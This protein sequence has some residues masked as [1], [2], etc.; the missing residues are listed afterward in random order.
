MNGENMV[1]AAAVAARTKL[2]VLNTGAWRATRL[3]RG[4]TRAQ[5]RLHGTG[6]KAKVTVRITDHPALH[7][8]NK[9][10]AAAYAAH[11]RITLP[12]VQDG[13]RLVP[14]GRELE[15]SSVM[16]KFADEHN[17]LVAEFLADYDAE[18]EAAPAKLN[19]LYDPSMWP[20]RAEVAR[21]FSFGTR[22]LAT[23]SEGEWGDWLV[24]S[25]SAAEAELRERLTEAL[26][27]VRDRCKSDGRLYAT[28]FDSIRELAELVPDLDFSAD[29]KYAPVVKAMKPLTELHA[30]LLRDD[31]TGRE[32][33][34]KRAASILSVLGGIE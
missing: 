27:R 26:E 19:G 28:V 5:N 33:A 12:T 4:E 32:K 8:L 34:A 10:H 29:Q 24:E 3:H 25:A 30:D 23:P 1:S 13:M 15:H 9:L 6:D 11:K 16:Q 18:R 31:E 22:Y 7:E 14:A 17:R 2:A 21:K 20:T